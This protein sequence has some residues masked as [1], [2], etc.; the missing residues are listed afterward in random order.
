MQIVFTAAMPKLASEEAQEL[1]CTS[2]QLK[3]K[4][5]AMDQAGGQMVFGLKHPS[6]HVRPSC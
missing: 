2:F 1:F 6:L 4:L 5:I 3:T